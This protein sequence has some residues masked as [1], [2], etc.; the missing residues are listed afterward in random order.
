MS[1]NCLSYKH[2]QQTNGVKQM[3]KSILV[4]AAF[5][6]SLYLG[7]QS[8]PK[9]ENKVQQLTN[10]SVSQEALYLGK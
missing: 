10:K 4:M 6:Y 2:K 3:F 5:G 7:V 9:F 8:T 1:L